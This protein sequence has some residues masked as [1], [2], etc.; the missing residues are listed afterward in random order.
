MDIMDDT[1]IDNKNPLML[2]IQA[3]SSQD[4]LYYHQ[5]LKQDDWKSF[6]QTMNSEINMHL[7][8]GNFS[9]I[10]RKTQNQTFQYCMQCG[11]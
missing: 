7:K 5:A 10:Q 6:R 8:E 3:I 4:T 2:A 9:L 1:F 11:N